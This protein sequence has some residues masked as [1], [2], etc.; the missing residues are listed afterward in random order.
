M[1]EA[2]SKCSEL[3]QLSVALTQLRVLSVAPLR[4]SPPPS[5]VLSLGVATLP[6]SRF[7]SSTLSVVLLTVVVVPLTVRLPPTVTCEDVANVA[8]VAPEKSTVP[9]KVLLPLMV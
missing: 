4:V 2:R 5:A 6:S 7:L 9:V 1:P 8:I 3:V